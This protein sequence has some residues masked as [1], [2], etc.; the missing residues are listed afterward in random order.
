MPAR[1]SG[2]RRTASHARGDRPGK[3]SCRCGCMRTK[4]RLR[5]FVNSCS[6]TGPGVASCFPGGRLAYARK[7][8]GPLEHAQGGSSML[9]KLA[10]I[11][12]VSA[13]A[14]STALAQSPTT[15]SSPPAST[16]TTE[17]KSGDA[18]FM[19]A[20]KPDQCLAFVFCCFLCAGD[21]RRCGS[22]TAK[23]V[24]F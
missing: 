11:S 15:T 1:Q 13:L 24:E 12:A 17:M 8:A 14:L 7:K 16:T 9:K 3:Q 23:A 2:F 21:H 19:A 20:Q 5:R 22:G 4:L 10:L 6:G 18:Q